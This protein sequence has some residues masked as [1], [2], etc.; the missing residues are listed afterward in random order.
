MFLTSELRVRAVTNET[1]LNRT[2]SETFERYKRQ[3]CDVDRPRGSECAVD[4]YHKVICVLQ[5]VCLRTFIFW[6]KLLVS[7]HNVHI[8][9]YETQTNILMHAILCCSLQLSEK[10]IDVA[11]LWKLN[12]RRL[13]SIQ[14]GTLLH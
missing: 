10:G 7:A 5:G 14:P 8:H 1:D 13:G 9:F 4:T 2:L 6:I 11:K 3:V 12:K